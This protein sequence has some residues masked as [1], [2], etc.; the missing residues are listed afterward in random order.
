MAPHKG[1]GIMFGGV[2]DKEESEEDLS[3]IFY[4]DLYVPC[5]FSSRYAY[6][7]ESNRYFELK[8]RTPRTTKKKVV[9]SR[10]KTDRAEDELKANL[11]ALSLVPDEEAV[12]EVVEEEESTF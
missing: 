6:Q 9:V 12:A 11:H 10:Q 2:F 1:R 8:L 3:S 7:I 5:D 4:N